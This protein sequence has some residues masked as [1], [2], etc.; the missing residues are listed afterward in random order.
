MDNNEKLT[1]PDLLKILNL[2]K[3]NCYV[4]KQLTKGLVGN[5]TKHAIRKCFGDLS[6]YEDL[7]KLELKI[8]ETE[9]E[10]YLY[11]KKTGRNIKE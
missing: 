8:I 1:Q 10:G 5:I 3:D 7:L 6:K 11:D 9:K 4:N 2:K